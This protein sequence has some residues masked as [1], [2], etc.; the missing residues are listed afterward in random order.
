MKKAKKNLSLDPFKIAKLTENLS[1]IKGGANN[2]D[3]TSDGTLT[4]HG[5]RPNSSLDCVSKA[6]KQ[7]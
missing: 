7:C 6:S 4:V 3:T 1:Y 5:T 2:N